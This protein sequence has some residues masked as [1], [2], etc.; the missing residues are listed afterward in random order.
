MK[1]YIRIINK[2]NKGNT[3]ADVIMAVAVFSVLS[4]V[5]MSLILTY[6]KSEIECLKKE[7]ANFYF[8]CISNEIIYEIGKDKIN[9]IIDKEAYI[10][11]SIICNEEIEKKKLT[12]IISPSVEDNSYYIK[13]QQEG[14]LVS[15]TYVDLRYGDNYEDEIS[16]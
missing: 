6:R 4:L 9:S 2:K 16:F 14:E 1:K 13:I 7:E 5:A 15:V 3:I 12:E 8:E 11:K 10:N